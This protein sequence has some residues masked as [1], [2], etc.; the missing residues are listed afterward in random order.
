MLGL[1]VGVAGYYASAN[2]KTANLTGTS[3]GIFEADARFQRWGLN[4]RAE[5][6]RV[7]IQNAAGITDYQR[8]QSMLPGMAAVGSAAQGFY[9]EA[10]YDILRPLHRTRQQVPIFARYEYVDTRAS[11]PAVTAPVVTQAQNYLT[12]GVTYLPIPQIAFKFDYRRLV[13]GYDGFAPDRYS[14]GIGFMY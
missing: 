10:G 12:V 6:A 2:N 5:Y 8:Q 1:D 4:L 14:L 9:A 11:L 7:F 3:V 13:A